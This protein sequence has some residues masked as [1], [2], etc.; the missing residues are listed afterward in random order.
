ME[1]WNSANAF[2]FYGKGGEVAERTGT[3]CS[4]SASAADMSGVR[5][6]ADDPT[7]AP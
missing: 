6:H 7:G 5:E 1:N 4:G 2:I 3:V